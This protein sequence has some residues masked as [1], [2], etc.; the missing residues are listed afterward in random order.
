VFTLSD[1]DTTPISNGALAIM[2]TMAALSFS[3]SRA[4]TDDE[5]KERALFAG[6]KFLHSAVLALIASILRYGEAKISGTSW[7]QE[8][9]TLSGWITFPI[10]AITVG[11]FTHSLIVGHVG[12]RVLNRLLLLNFTRHPDWDRTI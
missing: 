4:L 2:A 3:Y 6:E 12:V 11:L 9:A 8:H 10:L 7:M 5:Q 1:R